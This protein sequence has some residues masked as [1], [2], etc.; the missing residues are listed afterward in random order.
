MNKEQRAYNSVGQEYKFPEL[1]VAGSSPAVLT[2]YT[3]V[4]STVPPPVEHAF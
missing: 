4:T 1:N 3:E 2:Q